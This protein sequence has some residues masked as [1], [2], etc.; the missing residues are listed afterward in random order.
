MTHTTGRRSA[1]TLVELL[2]VIAIIGLLMALLLPAIQRVREA[3]NAMLCGN[4]IRQI[5]LA[6]H[7]YHTDYKR[8]P[9]GYY[10]HM[11]GAPL[12]T[13]G[14]YCG[15]LV[16]LL[17]YMELD[18]VRNSIMDTNKQWPLPATPP[19]PT[20]PIVL[21]LNE[22]RDAWWTI[23][24]NYFAAQAKI[25]LFECP[26]DSLRSD[27]VTTGVIVGMDAVSPAATYYTYPMPDGNALGRTNYLGVAGVRG[28]LDPTGSANNPLSTA[29]YAGVFMN[30]SRLTLGQITVKDGTSNT[31]FFG[32]TIGGDVTIGRDF[33]IA[34]AY[35]GC[36]P[37][38]YGLG[39]AKRPQTQGGAAWFRFS[40]T[41][42]AGVQFAFGDNSVRTLKFD[43][44]T[45]NGVGNGDLDDT[46]AANDYF[47]ANSSAEWKMYQRLAGWRDGPRIDLD[48]IEP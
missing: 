19:N 25:K 23:T 41:H 26:S 42:A 29:K 2:V 24:P 14:P 45:F 17:P 20:S 35:G 5:G 40:S 3:A 13:R 46:N 12:A 36:L 15:V 28:D 11:T 6:A 38:Q 4:N 18:S 7:N 9:P 21:N 34:W 27:I 47:L 8:L 22:I 10:G 31:V 43:N 16:C 48:V 1:F 30:R 32:E 37:T 44:T 33:A 39:S